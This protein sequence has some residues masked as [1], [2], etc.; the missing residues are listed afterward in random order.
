[1]NESGDTEKWEFSGGSWAVAGFSQVGAGKLTELADQ[2][3]KNVVAIEVDRE[4]GD[5]TAIYSEDNS[6]FVS[7]ELT[8]N[9]DL[10][11]T[12]EY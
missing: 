4:N 1:M 11:L 8:E 2:V 10:T 5:I 7:G 6:A 12:F 9:G 3:S